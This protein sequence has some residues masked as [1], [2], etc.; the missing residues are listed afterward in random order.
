MRGRK[1]QLTFTVHHTMLNLIVYFFALITRSSIAKY[2]VTIWVFK[3]CININYDAFFF[4]FRLNF[5]FNINL[6]IL[7]GG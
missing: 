2:L 4:P 6:F 3:I 5:I 7:I 1:K